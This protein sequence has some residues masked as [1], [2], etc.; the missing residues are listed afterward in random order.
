MAN[1]V[2]YGFHNLQDLFDRRV[3]DVGVPIVE[4]ALAATIAEHNRQIAALSG[5]FVRQ[6]TD[7]K[8][9]FRTA[10]SA[11]LMPLDENGRAL[12]IRPSGQYD[13]AFPLQRAGIAWGANYETR[14]KMTVAEANEATNT[15]TM[16]DARWMRDHI[17]AAL[18]SNTS[19]SFTDEE[20]GA[21]TVFGLANGDTVVYPIMT[22]ADSGAIDDHYLGQAA[23][24]AD[25]TNPYPT[26]HDEL[27]EHPSNSGDVIALIPTNL[28]AT[29][30]ALATFHPLAD[31]N[32]RLGTGQTQLVGGLGVAIPGEVIGYEDSKTWI[33][34]WKSL[35]DSRIIGVMTGGERA[36]AMRQDT[37][38]QLQG[39]N[40]VAE[41]DDHPWFEQQYLRKAG[42]GAWNRVGAVVMEI[43]DATYDIPTG[44]TSP[45]P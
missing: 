18:F 13:I 40:R 36:L 15:L 1:Q 25:A 16:A 21:L 43:S 11:R 3:V 34:E 31:P 28:R 8:T 33:V 44:Y 4:A 6:T 7:F 22:G 30:E 10:T 45:M 17:L 14:I 12:P 20:H 41:R 32:L 24:I 39:F 26:I 38:S 19:W 35:P 2:A 29:T 42:F 37:F 5:L 23:G 9:R 27:V